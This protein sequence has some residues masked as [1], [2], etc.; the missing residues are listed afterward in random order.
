MKQLSKKILQQNGQSLV[1]YALSLP[2]LIIFLFIV[3]NLGWIY[4]NKSRLQNAAE[5]AAIAGA[6][7]FCN[8]NGDYNSVLLIYEEDENYKNLSKTNVVNETVTAEE[9]AAAK[10]AATKSWIENLGVGDD[11]KDSWTKAAVE[12]D[13][14]FIGKKGDEKIY[15]E[16][17]LTEDVDY[18]FRIKNPEKDKDPNE[19]DYFTSSKIPAT[20]VVEI[21]K[22]DKLAERNLFDDMNALDLTQTIGNWEE[23]DNA[24]KLV[25]KY[26]D[27]EKANYKF[28]S[29]AEHRERYYYDGKWNH[30]QDAGKGEKSQVHYDGSSVYKYETITITTT[31][32]TYAANE[33][34]SLNL[35]FR[36]DV[37]LTWGTDIDKKTLYWNNYIA[38][39]LTWETVSTEFPEILTD[40]WDIGSDLTGTGITKVGT[41]SKS[42]YV[43]NWG[44]NEINLRVHAT[45]NFNEPFTTRETISDSVKA[46][47]EKSGLGVKSADADPLYVRIESEPMVSHLFGKSNIQRDFASVR[48]IILNFNETNMVSSD[49]EKEHN[50]TYRPLVI[51]YDGPEKNGTDPAGIRDSQ[52]VILN[53]NADFRGILFMPN[54]P[55]VINGN[56]HKF[57]GFVIAK[58]FVKLKTEDNYP[59]RYTREGDNKVIYFES[60]PDTESASG[61]NWIMAKKNDGTSTDWFKV[62]R[63]DLLDTSD[64]ETITVEDSVAKVVNEDYKPSDNPEDKSY[65]TFTYTQKTY[66]VK[67]FK[68]TDGSFKDADNYYTEGEYYDKGPNV[69]PAYV[70][71]NLKLGEF[72]GDKLNPPDAN[73]IVGRREKW[74]EAKK[75][76]DKVWSIFIDYKSN[77]VNNVNPTND[78]CLFYKLGWRLVT[79]NNKKYIAQTTTKTNS[80][81]DYLDISKTGNYVE[82]I[83]ANGKTAYV[84]KDKVDSTKETAYFQIKDTVT[85]EKLYINKT[86]TNYYVKKSD[87]EPLI[88]DK[89][90]NVQYTEPIS[91]TKTY[92]KCPYS[93][94]KKGFKP[95]DFNLDTDESDTHYSRCGAIPRRGRY[96]ALGAFEDDDDYCQ[97]MFFT[98]ERSKQ[99]F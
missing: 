4:L 29:T 19:P 73:I 82:V 94:W 28:N 46:R 90:G 11:G 76:N 96:K 40:N 10:S 63:S 56:N 66:A 13:S 45:F 42:Q 86:N 70:K 69:A 54:S 8:V 44:I 53:F 3:L 31:K 59:F 84:H 99:I 39:E 97:D 88:L 57:Q 81:D 27:E 91:P 36:Q 89:N 55:V 68:L 50:Y 51:F 71:H 85:N 22:V 7:K 49:N 33:V 98:T 87:A 15:Y 32:N 5:A 93:D 38:N 30:Y 67:K 77:L 75:N 1:L 60:A 58:E 79:Y 35:D 95:A 80:T 34:D 20:A 37:Q 14:T 74:W 24:K 72:E 18:I 12:I 41:P 64:Y 2:V 9:K 83:D 6:N 26:T 43:D 21:T 23:Q 65:Y 16:V 78:N 92:E 52:P 61:N 48:Q 62:N 47:Y 17:K 25:N